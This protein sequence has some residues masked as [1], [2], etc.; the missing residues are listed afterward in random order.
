MITADVSCRLLDIDFGGIEAVLTGRQLVPYNPADAQSYMRLARLGMHAALVAIAQGHPL[1]VSQPD[2]ILGPQLSAIK[3]DPANTEIYWKSKRTIHGANFGLTPYGAYDRGL[4]NSVKE[5]NEF[6]DYY[7]ALCP[8]LPIFHREVRKHAQEVGYLGGPTLPGRAPSIWDHPYGYR[9]AFHDV[10]SYRPCD[11]FTARKWLKDPTRKSRIIQMHGRWFQVQWGGDS[12][13][14]IAYYPQSIAS[15]R[16][17]EAELALFADPD[18]PDYIGDCYFGR[19]PLLVPVHDSLVLHIPNRCYDR[20]VEIAARVMQQPSPH[21]PIPVE[22]G[23]GS[24]LAIGVS[25][26]GGK[27][28]APRVSEAEALEYAVKSG[29][30]V[31]ANLLGMED[32]EV[33]AYVPH[34]GFDA[35]VLPVEDEDQEDWAALQR[36][37]A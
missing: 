6:F 22:W 9:L 13:A 12:K 11:E 34:A 5:A 27:N 23:W 15:G 3:K 18:S 7:H 32:I 25:A 19:T 31:R 1:D 35:S 26:K 20:V 21:L 29:H 16:L 10:L 36:V 37:V 17:K 4:F 14:V 30:P 2:D 8:T 24:H 28:W 33:P